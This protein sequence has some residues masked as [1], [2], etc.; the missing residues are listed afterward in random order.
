[1][2]HVFTWISTIMYL[3]ICNCLTIERLILL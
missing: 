3:H 1:M 2:L